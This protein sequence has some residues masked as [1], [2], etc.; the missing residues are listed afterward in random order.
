MKLDVNALR[1]LTKDEFRVLT[2]VEMGMKNHEIVPA[3]LVDRIA[4]LKH[5][6]AYKNMK[7]L[8]RHKLTHHDSSKYDGFRL[9]N[10]GYDYLAIRTM[11]SRGLISGVGRQIGVGKESDI[12]EVVTPEGETMALKLHR[13]GRTSFRAVKS[14]RDYLKHRNSYSW[15][16][17]S[18]L[19]A[20]KEY[21]FMKALGEHGFPVP[22]AVDW[23]RHCVLMTLVK[24]YPMV[25]VK[26][27]SDP[28]KAFDTV[29]GLITRLAQHG[30]IHCDF[31]EFNLMIDDE[32]NI[33]MIDFPQMVSITHRNAEMYFDRD[34]ECIFKFFGKRFNYSPPGIKMLKGPSDAEN[35][36]DDEEEGDGRPDFE[37]VAGGEESLDKVLEA[38]GFTRK[39]QETLEQF[40]ENAEGEEDLSEEEEEEEEE[41]KEDDS[42]N[43]QA[44]NVDNIS[45]A[46]GSFQK[47]TVDDRLDEEIDSSRD[48]QSLP[49]VS[50]E[51]AA[52]K[53]DEGD[54]S[55]SGEEEDPKLQ[56]RLEKT[57]NRAASHVKGGGRSRN[58]R[59]ASKDKG[60]RRS[61]HVSTSSGYEF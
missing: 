42:E 26:N 15:L 19:A 47:L 53:P 43:L 45:N 17:L 32:E 58:S 8:L 3:E 51:N 41:E 16:Y 25:Q 12:F 1:Y 35:L 61:R 13:L 49:V 6:G 48:P 22:R 5:G 23:N 36:D 30:L 4:G 18:R 46:G 56:K 9:T 57:R 44:E 60:G 50:E 11:V 7:T 24:G 39:D 14:K 54:E 34:V 21:A 33:T 20:L 37:T 59:N 52:T 28:A 2:A 40:I 29:L 55:E 27:L 31:N 38:S 10:L